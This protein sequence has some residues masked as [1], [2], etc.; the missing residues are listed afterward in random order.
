MY[1]Y[2]I[3]RHGSAAMSSIKKKKKTFGRVKTTIFIH[4]ITRRGIIKL[5]GSAVS[6]RVYIKKNKYSTVETT[7][8]IHVITRSGTTS[9]IESFCVINLLN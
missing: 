2:Y 6:L 8:F 7:M 9:F 1:L 4:V 3:R 5:H